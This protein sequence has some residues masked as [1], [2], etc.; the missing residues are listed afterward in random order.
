MCAILR[1]NMQPM[2]LVIISWLKHQHPLQ[3]YAV[4]GVGAFA[5]DEANSYATISGSSSSA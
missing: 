1:Y 5:R 3:R 4:A 2:I